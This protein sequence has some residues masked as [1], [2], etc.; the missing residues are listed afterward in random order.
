LVIFNFDS[1][2]EIARML[3]SYWRLF[4]NVLCADKVS[5]ISHHEDIQFP[6]KLDARWTLAGL[7]DGMYLK[8]D[9]FCCRMLLYNCLFNTLQKDFLVLFS[10][11]QGGSLLHTTAQ[12]GDPPP[13]NELLFTFQFS[14][15]SVNST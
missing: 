8:K 7:F 11:L 12:C 6:N 2:E 15:A 9:I 5:E 14:V 3:L 10:F 13:P 1:E 4:M